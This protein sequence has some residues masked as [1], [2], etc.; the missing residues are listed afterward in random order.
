MLDQVGTFEA[1][2]NVADRLLVTGLLHQL[3]CQVQMHL[4]HP[5]RQVDVKHDPRKTANLNVTSL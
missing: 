2:N 1:C 5:S 3:I 4:D